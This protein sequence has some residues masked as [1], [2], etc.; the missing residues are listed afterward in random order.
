MTLQ[1]SNK[2]WIALDPGKTTGIAVWY[3]N[4]LTLF[5]C[6]SFLDAT[7]YWA[8]LVSC[9][10]NLIINKTDL[11]NLIIIVEKPV[12]GDK[13]I[14]AHYGGIS[15]GSLCCTCIGMSLPIPELVMQAPVAR[16]QWFPKVRKLQGYTDHERDAL[17]HLFKYLKEK[18]PNE[19][20][21]CF[22]FATTRI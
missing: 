8:D 4:N 14:A 9:M 3:K 2:M 12:V 19:Y 7:F 11:S 18:E 16:R 10:R 21:E 15:I 13:F 20:E 1:V 22:S 5:S 6:Y 17:C